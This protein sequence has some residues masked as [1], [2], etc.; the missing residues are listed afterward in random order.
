MRA[1]ILIIKENPLQ[2]NVQISKSKSEKELSLDTEKLE[3]KQ[4]KV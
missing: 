4:G 1:Q 2:K 3:F